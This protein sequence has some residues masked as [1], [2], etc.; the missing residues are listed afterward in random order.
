[1]SKEYHWSFDKV[2][3]KNFSELDQQVQRR[4]VRWLD[5]HIEGYDNPRAWGKALE[6]DLGTLWRYRIGSYRV[7]ADIN[8]GKFEILVVKVAK[9]NDVYTN[10]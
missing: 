6:G 8:D 5:K 10:K 4:I 3:E 7:I 1:M 9:R 2:A